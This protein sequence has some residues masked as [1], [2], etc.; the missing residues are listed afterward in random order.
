MFTVTSK[1]FKSGKRLLLGNS[2]SLN[3]HSVRDETLHVSVKTP[4]P[5]FISASLI[6]T[7]SHRLL[8]TR[9]L[10]DYLL[11]LKE[12]RRVILCFCQLQP[13]WVLVFVRCFIEVDQLRLCLHKAICTT[14][15]CKQASDRL[16]Y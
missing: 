2:V 1:Y 6:I 10:T 7:G 3:F 4:S 13:K 8:G 9:P 16:C 15:L 5:G 14:R 12:I 11:P